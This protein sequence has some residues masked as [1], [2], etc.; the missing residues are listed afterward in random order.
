L[1]AFRYTTDIVS[2]KA[3]IKNFEKLATQ[4]IA[5]ID[6]GREP[7]IAANSVHRSA[8]ADALSIVIKE[9]ERRKNAG[10]RG[11]RPPGYAPDEKLSTNPRT[12]QK[13]E[14]MRRYRDKKKKAVTNPASQ[15]IS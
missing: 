8:F 5:A 10:A 11:G 9:M 15:S 4:I 13:R 2:E 3:N 6:S 12:V 7:K 14:A 1:K